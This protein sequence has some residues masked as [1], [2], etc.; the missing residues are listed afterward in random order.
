MLFATG[1]QSNSVCVHT[2]MCVDIQIDMYTVYRNAKAVYSYLCVCKRYMRCY[3][4][5]LDKYIKLVQSFCFIIQ[6]K[7]ALLKSGFMHFF[8]SKIFRI[9]LCIYM[10]NAI[11][12]LD[13][14]IF[15]V[16]IVIVVVVVVIK[17]VAG[18]VGRGL[19]NIV[20]CISLSPKFKSIQGPT[21]SFTCFLTALGKMLNAVLSS[22]LRAKF[23]SF[24]SQY[25]P[26]I[27]LAL[28]KQS[29]SSI[30]VHVISLPLPSKLIALS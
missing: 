28:I 20:C 4:L 15:I 19:D 18:R 26:Y 8:F 2:H 5:L 27:L 13:S 11:L 17:M 9:G 1:T 12:P 10:C 21:F 7:I 30:V 25:L 6:Y 16:V 14:I 3:I 29:Q 24:Q 22:S 23:K